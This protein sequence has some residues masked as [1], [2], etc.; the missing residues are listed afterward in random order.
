MELEKYV[1]SNIMMYSILSTVSQVFLQ[2]AFPPSGSLL[3]GNL[4]NTNPPILSTACDLSGLGEK[5]VA[6]V[7]WR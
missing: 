2:L 4:L 7:V 5:P 6:S 3:L 1:Y